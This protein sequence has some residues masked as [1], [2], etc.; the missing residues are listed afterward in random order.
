MKWHGVSV[1]CGVLACFFSAA[2]QSMPVVSGGDLGG[3][4]ATEPLGL[5]T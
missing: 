1:V 2:V 4:S 5:S 3:L